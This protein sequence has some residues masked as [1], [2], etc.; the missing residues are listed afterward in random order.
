M[1]PQETLPLVP[2]ATLT[3]HATTLTLQT[4]PLSTAQEALRFKHFAHSLVDTLPDI[5]AETLLTCISL[6]LRYIANTTLEHRI[7]TARD[8][9]PYALLQSALALACK[10]TRD[11]AGGA[12]L[13]VW[14]RGGVG[15]FNA[16]TLVRLETRLLRAVGYCVGL[17]GL[18]V[19]Q[20]WRDILAPLVCLN[21]GAKLKVAGEGLACPNEEKDEVLVDSGYASGREGLACPNEEKDEVLVDSGMAVSGANGRDRRKL[22]DPK[23]RYTSQDHAAALTLQTHPLT[24]V[25]ER[26]QFKH[27]AHA[28]VDILPDT[29]PTTL[30]A[31]I[32]Y[33]RRY[34]ASRAR[35]SVPQDLQPYAAFQ[36]ALALACKLA[37]DDTRVSASTWMQVGCFEARALVRF[38]ARLLAILEYDVGVHAE[39]DGVP[40]LGCTDT[41][42]VETWGKLDSAYG[43]LGLTGTKRIF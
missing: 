3:D 2:I 27:F 30:L 18:A 6:L 42:K 41:V 38:E 12:S 4:H 29:H 35:M 1:N 23:E 14:T 36:A 26:C 19:L 20:G 24:T 25:Q 31:C 21:E 17:S 32:A 11:D 10:A 34:A 40:G 22:R 16:G 39:E 37:R 33:L 9:A 15:C 28:L 7:K 5:N 13:H 43:T 8:I